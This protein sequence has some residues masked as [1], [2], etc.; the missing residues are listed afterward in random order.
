MTKLIQ[1][2]PVYRGP[3]ITQ[4]FS[5]TYW[6]LNRFFSFRAYI[7]IKTDIND[8]KPHDGDLLYPEKLQ[9]MLAIAEESENKDS[10]ADIHGMWYPTV[11]RCVFSVKN[12]NLGNLI[13]NARFGYCF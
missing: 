3:A 7:F 9:M 13:E 11:R 12:K 4:L 6:L 2:E 1:T 10:P 5:G 8:F